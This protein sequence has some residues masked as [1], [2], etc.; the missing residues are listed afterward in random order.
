ML[1]FLPFLFAFLASLCLVPLLRAIFVFEAE[2]SIAFVNFWSRLGGAAIILG[3]L[4]TFIFNKSLVFDAPKIG[5]I[6]AALAIFVFGMLDDYF[7]FPAWPQLVF[8][9]ALG[10][11]ILFF[12]F[13]LDFLSNPFG[14]GPL[15]L[16]GW[17]FQIF[18]QAFNFWGS[19]LII[20]WVVLMINAFNWLDGVDGLA[21]GVGGISFLVLFLL[22]VSSLINQPPLGIISL[23]MAGV[24]LGFLAL[25]FPWR[26]KSSLMMGTSGSIFL[27]FMLAALSILSGAKIMTI[28][29]VLSLPIL[30][31]LWVIWSRFKEGKSIFKKD[32]RHLHFKLL[33]IGFSAKFILVFYYLLAAILGILALLTQTSG[34]IFALVAVLIL[35]FFIMHS[36]GQGEKEAKH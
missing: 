27:G 21:G 26:G 4:L 28:F 11:L 14:S 10:L 17:Q 13:H 6:L 33:K 30:D 16:D 34:K 19:L 1:Y 18:G 15:R 24:T 2:K 5:L 22:S 8:Q 3:F 12:G 29:L 31:A 35:V 23:I 25:N 32:R 9:I 20:A 7:D 36:I